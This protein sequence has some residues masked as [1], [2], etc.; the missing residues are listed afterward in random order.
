[1]ALRRAA[2]EKV[3]DNVVGFNRSVVL[4]I[5]KHR[6]GERRT[7][8]GQQREGSFDERLSGRV[9]RR[10]GHGAAFIEETEHQIGAAGSGGNIA[11]GS[12]HQ[13]GAAG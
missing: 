5:A 4:D 9:A 6:R 13:A 7:W 12:P 1:M 3:A 2:A 10:S 8:R 11:N